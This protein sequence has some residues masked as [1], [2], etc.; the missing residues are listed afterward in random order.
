MCRLVRPMPRKNLLHSRHRR[1]VRISVF[2]QEGISNSYFVDA[3][4][5]V[6]IALIGPVAARGLTAPA[7]AQAIAAR[8]REGYHPRAACQCR[9]RSLPAVLYSRRGQRA[10]PISLS[11]R[12]DAWRPR[13][14]SRAVIRR[15]PTSAMQMLTRTM[16]GAPVKSK[17]P[18]QTP[19][20]PG[21]TDQCRRN[22]GS[23]REPDQAAENSSRLPRAG[24]R[25]VSATSMDFVRVNRRAAIRSES[26]RIARPAAR[27]PIAALPSLRRISRLA[28]IAFR[29]AAIWDL[30]TFCYARGGRGI[31]RVRRISYMA[32]AQRARLMR[33]FAGAAPSRN[34]RL[35]AAWRQSALSARDRFRV[36]STSLS[37]KS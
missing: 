33:G 24:R 14:P 21:D 32:M 5:Y 19:L 15:A 37:K 8:L 10:R 11:A 2:G 25:A 23:E 13:S 18:L 16:N 1:S 34:P 3:A 27:M 20:R 36:R 9:G 22:G 17:V 30:A 31:A 4:G 28:S 7:L 12:H 29:W 26:S 6:N 35:H